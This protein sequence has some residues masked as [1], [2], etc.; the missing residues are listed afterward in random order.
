MTVDANNELLPPAPANDTLASLG[1]L[2]AAASVAEDDDEEFEPPPPSAY[3]LC[4]NEGRRGF[5]EAYIWR[6]EAA[7]W[8]SVNHIW[9]QLCPP[10]AYR[11]TLMGVAAGTG[12][13]GNWP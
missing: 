13:S 10:K 4:T 7:L 1:S 5:L 6:G 2:D 3:P 11:C 8:E 12:G 9:N